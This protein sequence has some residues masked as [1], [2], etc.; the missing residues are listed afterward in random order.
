MHTHTHTHTQTHS[1]TLKHT[2]AHTHTHRHTHTHPHART[3]AHT[4]THT[5]THTHNCYSC[6]SVGWS[7]SR[8]PICDGCLTGCCF[9]FNSLC[10]REMNRVSSWV[11]VTDSSHMQFGKATVCLRTENCWSVTEDVRRHMY[12]VCYRNVAQYYGVYRQNGIPTHFQKYTI[13]NTI[14][15]LCYRHKHT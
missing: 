13:N 2:H 14:H 8:S 5:L 11:N 15:C 12:M 6:N 1:H 4:R 10:W 9:L 7:T 3:H